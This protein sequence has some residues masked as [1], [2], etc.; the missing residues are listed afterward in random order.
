MACESETPLARE[1]FEPKFNDEFQMRF[2]RLLHKLNTSLPIKRI[3]FIENE[4]RIVSENYDK[5]NLDTIK[6]VT[7]LYVLVDLSKQG[8]IFE[9]ENDE[10]F[11]R[12]EKSNLNNKDYIRY[13]LSAETNAQFEAPNIRSFITDMERPKI[14]NEHLI[15]IQNL[16]GDKS[17]LIKKIKNNE[18]VC[19]PYLQLVT[20]ETDSF[21]GYQLYDIWRYFRYTWS[22]PYKTTP[23]RNLYYL[24][25]DR[26][27]EY[28]PIIG[29]FALGNSI[30]NL[31]TRDN[32][33]GW[34]ISSIQKNM[35]PITSVSRCQRKV[36]GCEDKYVSATITKSLETEEEAQS[37]ID[38]YSKE[39]FQLLEKN[40]EDAIDELYVKDLGYHKQ[41]KYPK[42]EYLEYLKKVEQEASSQ[43]INN[44]NARH[45]IDWKQEAEKP[46]F[47]RKR[48]T[49][50]YKLLQ[51]KIT[52]NHTTGTYTERMNELLKNDKGRSAISVALVANRK[53]KIGSN[54][55]DIIVCGSIPPYNELLGGKL[56]S[57]L[58]CSPRVI[59]DYNHQYIKQISEIASRMSGKAI[60]RD[61]RLAFLGTTSLYVA[62]S[63]QYNRIKVPLDNGSFLQYKRLGITEGYGTVFF[64]ERTVNNLNRILQIEDGGK[65]INHTFGE[66]TSPRFRLISKGL[67]YLG[68]RPNSFLQHYSPRIVYGIDLAENTND[69]LMGKT[70][71]LKYNFSLDDEQEINEKTQYLIDYWYNR[72]L[73]KRLTTVDIFDRLNNFNV[74]NFMLGNKV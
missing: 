47:R 33:I 12:M 56:V 5:N 32:E 40:I 37:R 52:I 10:L 31:T 44:K 28:H 57:I 23:G 11:L 4:A 43:A 35:K 38:N 60:I 2:K 18:K 55:M 67:A 19:D 13:R 64:S 22:I 66:G 41:T 59:C 58:A 63:S 68:L 46:L 6:Y 70:D 3:E 15:S 9:V 61:S 73:T 50:L 34:S 24:V 30:L 74:E 69:F 25:R 39:I 71:Q 72:W 65:R 36:A 26:S 8:W 27:Q 1:K 49:E 51:A 53:R 54:M 45:D 17:Q 21:S 16:I 14:Y 29:I 48:A 20:K 7:S 42:P 62:G